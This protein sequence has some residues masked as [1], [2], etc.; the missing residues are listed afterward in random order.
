MTLRFI[1]KRSE[2]DATS[3]RTSLAAAMTANNWT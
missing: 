3:Q 2:F 1:F